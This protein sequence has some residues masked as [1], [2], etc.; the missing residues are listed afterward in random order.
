LSYLNNQGIF[1]RLSYDS[2]EYHPLL[3]DERRKPRN[4][5]HALVEWDVVLKGAYEYTREVECH[6]DEVVGGVGSEF[7]GEE[8][9]RWWVSGS[10]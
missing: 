1:K 5:V 2:L 4:D 10:L 3:E 7:E 9:L 8:A 6:L